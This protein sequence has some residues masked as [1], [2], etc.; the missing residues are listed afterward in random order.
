MQLR[1][2][3]P[4]LAIAGLFA[5]PA[6]DAAAQDAQRG[7]RFAEMDRN[8]DGVLTRTEWRGNDRSFRNHDWNNDGVLSGDELRPGAA[9][10]N[11]DQAAE[12]FDSP[13]REYELQDWTEENFRNL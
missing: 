6:A 11:R 7:R 2:I 3:A 12:D 9:R 1:T 4:A 5:F 8:N 10:R 13:D